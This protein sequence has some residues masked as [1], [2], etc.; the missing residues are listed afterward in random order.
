MPGIKTFIVSAMLLAAGVTAQ[1]ADP[2]YFPLS[3]GNSWVYKVT[4]GRIG[5]TDTVEVTGTSTVAGRSYFTVKFFGRDVLLRTTA[6]GTLLEYDLAAKL[7]KTW[8]AFGTEPGT[9][10]ATEIDNCDK[11]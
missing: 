4:T 6:D 7:E 3:V 2:D 8:I 1:A 11:T 9:S 5:G 10:F